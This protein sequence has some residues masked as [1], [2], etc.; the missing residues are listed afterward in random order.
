[1]NEIEMLSVRKRR[2][3]MK[4]NEKILLAGNENGKRKDETTWLS[5]HKGYEK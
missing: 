5:L 3:V 4:K 2:Q 1:M